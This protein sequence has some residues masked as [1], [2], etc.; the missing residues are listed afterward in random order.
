MLK[1][2]LIGKL[3]NI[4]GCRAFNYFLTFFS[5]HVLL[6]L[7]LPVSFFLPFFNLCYFLPFICQAEKHQLISVTRMNQYYAWGYTLD[8]ISLLWT[9][10]QEISKLYTRCQIRPES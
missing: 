7:F 5:F 4:Y 2:M 3:F 1:K 6:S 8:F 10:L 9:S